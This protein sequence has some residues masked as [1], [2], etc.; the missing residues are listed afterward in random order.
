MVLRRTLVQRARS[1]DVSD[2]ARLRST[3]VSN[4]ARS[5]P[6]SSP[7]SRALPPARSMTSSTGAVSSGQ[8]RRPPHDAEGDGP[9]RSMRQGGPP[10][11]RCARFCVR[12][13]CWWRWRRPRSASAQSAG[14]RRGSSVPKP[15]QVVGNGAARVVVRTR[16]RVGGEIDGRSVNRYLRRA[17]RGYLRSRAARAGSAVRLERAQRRPPAGTRLRPRQVR[18]RQAAGTDTRRH[19]LAPRAAGAPR[20]RASSSG[21]HGAAACGRG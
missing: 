15:D 2:L 3:D 1:T 10:C 18:R 21:R 17:A 13:G 9:P 8:E 4:T 6:V 7:E 5:V 11:G 12:P 19:A 20:R 16:A 14:D